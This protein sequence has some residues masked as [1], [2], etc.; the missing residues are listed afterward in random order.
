MVPREV[1]EAHQKHLDKRFDRLESMYDG[2]THGDKVSWAGFI[3]TT[4][5]LF[6]ISAGIIGSLL[7]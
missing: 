2:H 4:L 5:T 1:F 3:S 6:A 7:P